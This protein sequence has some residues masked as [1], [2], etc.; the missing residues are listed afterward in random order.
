MTDP[1]LLRP[2]DLLINFSI[3][4]PVSVVSSRPG[5]YGSTDVTVALY[6]GAQMV[7]GIRQLGPNVR[8]L[9]SLW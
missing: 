5:Q 1:K 7:V 8:V 2:G 3:Y 6:N 9:K 4:G